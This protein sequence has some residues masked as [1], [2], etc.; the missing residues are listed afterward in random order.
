MPSVHLQPPILFNT[1]QVIW[2][3]YLLIPTMIRIRY[4]W[5]C[6]AMYGVDIAYTV[7]SHS[8]YPIYISKVTQIVITS[9]AAHTCNV[10]TWINRRMKIL[11]WFR[12]FILLYE[13]TQIWV[14]LIKMKQCK[15][16]WA[17]TVHTQNTILAVVRSFSRRPGQMK[18]GKYTRAE[19]AERQR[20]TT[21]PIFSLKSVCTRKLLIAH[22][23]LPPHGWPC[24]FSITSNF[25][26]QTT[27]KFA[28]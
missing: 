9:A 28:W 15:D 12:D 14:I 13:S 17:C 3:E 10:I 18:I 19:R 5:S 1:H 20:W 23:N 16:V 26:R 27:T 6:A 2:I 8:T 22:T 7:R 11:K 21:S 24:S 4:K 25:L